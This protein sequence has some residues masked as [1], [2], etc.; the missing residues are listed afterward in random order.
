MVIDGIIISLVIGLLRKGSLSWITNPKLFKYGW[1]FPILLLVQLITFSFQNQFSWLGGIS[2]YLFVLVY[3]I[4]LFFLWT[5]RDQQ[6]FYIIFAGV[7]LNFIVMAVNG[8]RM[9]VSE[10]A[11]LILDPMYVEAI[12]NGYYAKHA[13]LTESTLV[14]FLGDIIPI[15][16]PYPRSQVISIGDVI[17]NIGIFL[18]IQEKMLAHKNEEKLNSIKSQTI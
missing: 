1:V 8:G 14:P 18:Y 9:P 11:S 2:N 5:N 7:L 13:L 6:G 17:M 16:S 4:G 15:T 10:E 12:K 3:I